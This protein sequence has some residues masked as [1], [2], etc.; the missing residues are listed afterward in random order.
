MKFFKS[1]LAAIAAIAL[2]APAAAQYGKDDIAEEESSGGLFQTIKLLLTGGA[3]ADLFEADPNGVIFNVTDANYRDVLFQD[4]WIVTF[5]SPTSV[6]CA[7]Y[8]PTYLDVATTMQN[9]TNTRFAA[10]WV[11]DNSRLATRFF[12]P[13]R[14]PFVVY[15][16]DG[17]FR[18]IPYNRNETQFL[19]DFIEEE[20]YKNYPI[21]SGPMSPTST[22]AAY[23]EKYADFADWIGSYTSWMPKWMIYIVA[24]SMSGM[25][26]N[27]FSGGSSYSSDPSKYSHLN[28]D[29]TLK[30]KV[31]EDSPEKTEKK[32]KKSSKTSSSTKKKSSKKEKA[33]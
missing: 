28:P 32:E 24:G 11:D 9:E 16:K 33:N 18:Q 6:P 15:A 17:E 4:E 13:S 21:M 14:L 20:Q 3:Q 25:V 7:D 31:V 29:G 22:L 30:K 12:V 8:F 23:F 1:S 26:F 10:V 27:L 5:C 19:I 2:I